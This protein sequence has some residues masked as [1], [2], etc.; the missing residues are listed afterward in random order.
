MIF[1]NLQYNFSNFVGFSSSFLVQYKDQVIWAH[2]QHQYCNN[3]T[4]QR[5]FFFHLLMELFLQDLQEFLWI[6]CA[7]RQDSCK[8]SYSCQKHYLGDL[9]LAIFGKEELVAP[10]EIPDFS[11]LPV[12]QIVSFMREAKFETLTMRPFLEEYYPAQLNKDGSNQELVE[13]RKQFTA[14]GD[15]YLARY[16]YRIQTNKESVSNLPI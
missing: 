7:A 3:C 10:G 1:S 4:K 6:S 12:Y 11:Y 8:I 2:M 5:S 14:R 16:L 15:A 9:R 13:A